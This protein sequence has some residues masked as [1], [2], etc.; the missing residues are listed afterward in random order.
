MVHI[1]RKTIKL[2][3]IT[4]P[5]VKLNQDHNLIRHILIAMTLTLSGP[6][7]GTIRS[8]FILFVIAISKITL[9]TKKET[10]STSSGGLAVKN[11]SL[12]LVLWKFPRYYIIGSFAFCYRHSIV[13]LTWLQ[14]EQ[15]ADHY[16]KCAYAI[17]D[18]MWL[19]LLCNRIYFA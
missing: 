4:W 10:S 15:I 9:T 13:I 8:L 18:T 1:F 11:V 16:Q 12:V 5:R 14:G 7:L 2:N 17:A 19:K 3:F 6:K